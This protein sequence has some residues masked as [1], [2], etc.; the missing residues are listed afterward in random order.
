MTSTGDVGGWKLVILCLNINL[1]L[2]KFCFVLLAKDLLWH[3]QIT[4]CYTSYNPPFC[5]FR[6]T[7]IMESNACKST[8]CVIS[9]FITCFSQE[10]RNGVS[11]FQNFTPKLQSCDRKF[12][13]FRILMKKREE[14][15]RF[16]LTRLLRQPSNPVGCNYESIFMWQCRRGGKKPMSRIQKKNKC[17]RQSNAPIRW[18]DT[19][20]NVIS[21][22]YTHCT[23]SG[24][25]V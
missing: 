18:I 19:N 16:I 2:Y 17:E 21:S 12:A 11:N 15:E 8:S 22:R 5:F 25:Q 10:E 4:T 20:Y 23:T 3:N 6:F 13:T 14:S 1:E 9:F 24:W 7:A